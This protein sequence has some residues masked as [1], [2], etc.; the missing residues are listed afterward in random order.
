MKQL[1]GPDKPNG[2]NFDALCRVGCKGLVVCRVGCRLVCR[3]DCKKFDH[4]PDVQHVA[5]IDPLSR[6]EEEDDP[7]FL[8][9]PKLTLLT[10]WVPLLASLLVMATH[11]PGVYC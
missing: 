1:Q 8:S 11:L 2:G 5:R 9:C 10:F 3:V 7:D 6:V 4:D